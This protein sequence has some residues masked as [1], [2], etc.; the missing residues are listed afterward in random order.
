MRCPLSFFSWSILIS[1]FIL[2]EKPLCAFK[3]VP[4]P[5]RIVSLNLCAD[6]L[7]VDLADRSQIA[8]LTRY[9]RNPEM[10]LV[11]KE[12]QSLPFTY[13]SAEEL[14]RLNPDLIITSSYSHSEFL[15]LLKK[16]HVKIIDLSLANSSNEIIQQIRLIAEAIGHPER[17]EKMIKKMKY[18][19]DHLPS[20]AGHRRVAAYYQRQGYLSGPGSLVDDIM[21]KAGLKNLAASLH[22]SV[23]SR[24]SL[25]EIVRAQPDFLIMEQNGKA[26][27]DQGRA[28]LQHPLL[29]KAI[30]ESRH[31]Y[32][33]AALT[34]C[35]SP[36][37]PRA[38]QILDEQMETFDHSLR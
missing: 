6:E 22:K 14:I 18:A 1:L 28:M 21:T 35:G 2:I 8:A 23:L 9:A 31:L 30:P 13:G 3:E 29:K 38:I 32:I 36:D 12:A 11:T 17:G 10:S 27:T 5:A 16:R 4:R 19:L 34:L 33:P 24:L 20:P 15:S 25:E 26:V 7:L 37:Y